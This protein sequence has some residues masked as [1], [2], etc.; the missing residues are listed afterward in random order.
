MK[1]NELS[2]ALV[3]FSPIAEGRRTDELRTFASIFCGGKD[4]SVAARLKR[5]T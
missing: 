2:A 3:A 4:E 5:L 1:A